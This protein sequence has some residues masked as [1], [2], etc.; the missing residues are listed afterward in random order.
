LKK[1]S[2]DILASLS[3]EF[4]LYIF[5]LIFGILTARLLGPEGKGQLGVIINVAGLS[6][7]IFS[8]RFE[9]SVTYFLP[10]NKDL[11]G[12][13]ILYGLIVGTTTNLCLYLFATL[14][15]NFFYHVL[16]KGISISI[17]ILILISFST[18]LWSFVNYLLA[19]LMLFRIRAV[20]M[21]F[22][23]LI[24]SIEVVICLGVFQLNLNE[25]IFIMGSLETLLYL[26][27]LVYL[28]IRS[29]HKRFHF[30]TFRDM[31]KYSAELFP[32]IVSDLVTLRIDVFFLNYFSGAAQVG[33]Y[34]VA[35][36]MANVLLYMPT[37]VR[38]VLKSYVAQNSKDEITPKLTRL[39]IVSMILVCMILV[40]F[41]V[42]LV[43]PVLYGEEFLYSR[44]LFLI[45]VP[46]TMF[47]GVH[48]LI[49]SDLEG[50]G[51]P[52]KV[53]VISLITAI[54]TII[55]D[56]TLIPLMQATGAAL[57]STITYGIGLILAVIIYRRIV[58]VRLSDLL[59]PK[60]EDLS[61]FPRVL[62]SIF[63]ITRIRSSKVNS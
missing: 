3:G 35:I 16:L 48:S 59:I 33:I 2:A 36:S 11:L 47:W 19:G 57:V 56:M 31:F 6:A 53:S 44:I 9:R 60:V 8:L 46:G 4:F 55:L 12:E 24:K 20:F 18:Y 50:R 10:K 29:E 28:F 42:L 13:I 7:M 38:N 27:I 51:L 23:Y 62:F 15:Y 34:T 5:A 49:L 61:F 43:I 32:G 40:P 52:R 63:N 25:L 26:S 39:L 37:A 41:V 30:S 54:L 58:K 22:S 1:I 45:L 17:W 14:F 21:G